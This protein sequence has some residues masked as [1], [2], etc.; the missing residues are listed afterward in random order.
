[1]VPSTRLLLTLAVL[2]P[3]SLL[4]VLHPAGGAVLGL[5]MVCI[6]LLVVIDGLISVRRLDGVV[7]A[8]NPL[9]RL[10]RL[11]WAQVGVT[12]NSVRTYK[13]LRVGLPLPHGFDSE[14][15]APVCTV[16]KA[17]ATWRVE[18]SVQAQNRGQVEMEF[19]H[20]GTPSVLGF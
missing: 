18:W 19:L 12:L 16:P 1:M 3:L 14:D 10:P 5:T 11:E 6:G 8:E 9:C 7:S 13:H 4:P 2:L 17:E 15:L 20:L